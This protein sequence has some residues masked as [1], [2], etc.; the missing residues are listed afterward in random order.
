MGKAL[1]ALPAPNTDKTSS[2]AHDAPDQEAPVHWMVLEQPVE[3]AEPAQQTLP[4]DLPS[5]GCMKMEHCSLPS[6]ARV[7]FYTLPYTRFSSC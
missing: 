5:Q 7:L 4:A 3:G 2:L 6:P 1:L